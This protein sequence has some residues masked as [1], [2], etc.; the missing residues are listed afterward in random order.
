MPVIVACTELECIGVKARSQGYGT[1]LMAGA[2][3]WLK[4]AID[5]VDVMCVWMH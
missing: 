2:G 3:T 4:A 5:R 1:R